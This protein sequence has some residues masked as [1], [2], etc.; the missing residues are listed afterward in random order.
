[1]IEVKKLV[2]HYSTKGGVTVTA[3]DDVSI[4]FPQTGMVFLLGKSGSGKS[5]LLNVAGGLDKPDSGE[6]IVQGKSSKEFSPSDF[7]SYR[8]TFIGFIFQEYNILDEFSVE[9]NIALALQIQ[10]KPNDKSAVN[11]LLE[12]VD[13]KGFGKRKPNTLSGGQKQR[14]AIARALIKEPEIIMADEPTGALDSNTGK[15]VFD[16]LKKLSKTK[17]VIVVSHDKDFAEQ[18]ADRIIELKDGQIISDF[19]KTC[20]S[21]KPS[22]KNVEFL[23]A[24]TIS[25]KNAKDITEDDIKNIVNV[26][27]ENGGEAIITAGKKELPNV[28][29][30]CGINEQGNKEYFAKT[31]DVKF[32]QYDGKD[33]KFIKSRLPASHAFKM[34]VSGLKTKPIR[35]IFAIFLSILSF[36]L[37]GV[38]STFMLYDSNY[39]VSKALQ[40]ASYPSITLSKKYSYISQGWKVDA[41]TGEESLQ[42]ENESFA[43]TRFGVRELNIKN[44]NG[45]CYFAG[46]FNFSNDNYN[47]NSAYSMTLD[48]VPVSVESDYYPVKSI[49]GFTDCGESYMSENGFNLI[50]GRYPTAT[51][52][53]AIPEYVAN[54]F[55][56][57]ESCGVKSASQ[58]VGKKLKLIK[59]NSGL[60]I[61]TEIVG[62]YD[63]G[64]ILPE[65]DKLNDNSISLDQ[66]EKIKESLIDYLS[67]G[68]NTI[69]YVSDTFYDEYKDNIPSNIYVQGE[70]CRGLRLESNAI[71]ESA[72][73]Y[74]MGVYTEKT[75]QRYKDKFDLY[76]LSDESKIFSL[77][78]N[79][80]WVSK[81]IY[82]Q[83]I[84][85]A[86]TINQPS[87]LDAKIFYKDYAGGEGE[88]V[89]LGYFETDA[90]GSLDYIIH[91]KF[92]EN[93]TI[94]NNFQQDSFW[95]NKEVSDYTEPKDAKYNYIIALTDNSQNQIQS[96]LSSSD[97]ISYCLTSRIYQE[98]ENF[99][100]L[101]S[102][103]Q[104]IFLIVGVV[105]GLF[106]ALML[107]N[108][109]SASISA[110]KRDIGILRAIGSRGID[111]FK[112]FFSEAGVITAICVVLSI[113]L[114]FVTCGILNALLVNMVNVQLLNFNI[115]NVALLVGVALVISFVATFFPVY[116]TAKKAPVESIR[117]L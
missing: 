27:K 30:A 60:V 58:L 87:K 25:I 74:A 26:L 23:S 63:V 19:S 76:G 36:V 7:D 48:G 52:E 105:L 86:K 1:M 21:D 13:L 42:F 109:I 43:F 114:S 92:V 101:I 73:D 78:E 24:D 11:A 99:L 93:H 95:I 75:Y 3:L 111:V 31:I 41:E 103:L 53:I 67:N 47:S 9:Q 45:P 32:E 16:T 79:Q 117:E 89:V 81:T 15:Q 14:V 94:K 71:T 6:I 20:S 115:I 12:Q 85:G 70:I 77:E 97:G 98:M 56:S 69:L 88:L 66:R 35:L 50:C 90:E 8:N 54:L 96:A 55:I 82:Q 39:S 49:F 91:S 110:K 10:G 44:S 104:K 33:T 2:K 106:S 112:I 107:F 40:S 116:F 37:F 46:I 17:L 22:I 51:T 18:Y 102:K 61:E 28:K 113:V 59:S 62:V 5:T 108:F 38:L 68:F 64:D 83:I 80:V 57:T 72:Q 84:D 100:S 34:G 29:R 65:Y 4:K